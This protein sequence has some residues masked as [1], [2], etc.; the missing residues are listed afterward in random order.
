[1]TQ[2]DDQPCRPH[3]TTGH[4][5]V[6]L[7]E[8]LAS[9]A[10]RDGGIYLDATFGGGGYA[11]PSCAPPPARSGRS[12]AIPT[13]SPAAPAW[14]RI[15]PAACTSS[16]A[17]SATCSP[18]CRR[19]ACTRSM[20]SCST[21]ASPHSSSTSPSAASPSARMARSTCA[22]DS[23]GRRRPIWSTRCSERDLADLLFQL[24]EERAS[25]RIASAIVA[26]ARRG[27]DHDHRPPRLASS[28]PCCRPTAPA[29]IPRPAASRRC[30]SG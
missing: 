23:M 30:A 21:S 22:W 8:M 3:H 1:M 17:S 16:R 14:P 20:A 7:T 29:S 13:P 12:T 18:C 10:P 19:P 6:L 26:A 27:A 9:L 24:G 15:F 25:R 2:P 11:R 4:I 28:A 5:P